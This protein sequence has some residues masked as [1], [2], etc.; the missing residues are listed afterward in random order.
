MPSLPRLT[1]PTP[2]SISSSGKHAPVRIDRNFCPRSEGPASE[3]AS[4]RDYVNSF[5]TQIMSQAVSFNLF[6]Y[7]LMTRTDH[8][9]TDPVTRSYNFLQH[10]ISTLKIK[11]DH[12]VRLIFPRVIQEYK[13]T[14][15]RPIAHVSFKLDCHICILNREGER[16]SIHGSHVREKKGDKEGRNELF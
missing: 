10:R 9:E 6:R 4:H 3:A 12:P 5:L 14:A 1:Y 8:Y 7:I 16:G 15:A 13:G 11:L 2:K